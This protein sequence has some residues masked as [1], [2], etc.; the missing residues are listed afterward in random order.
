[1]FSVDLAFFHLFSFLFIYFNSLVYALADPGST[2]CQCCINMNAQCELVPLP[3][4]GQLNCLLAALDAIAHSTGD[5]TIL[6]GLECLFM[7]MLCCHCHHFHHSTITSAVTVTAANPF[8]S[9]AKFSHLIL[10]FEG[11]LDVLCYQVCWSFLIE[12]R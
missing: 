8:S 9:S 5:P 4:Y 7:G 11:I 6:T 12:V 3:L 2:C 1:M 10:T